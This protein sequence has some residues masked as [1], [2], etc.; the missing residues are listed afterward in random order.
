M[1][2]TCCLGERDG[3]APWVLQEVRSHLDTLKDRLDG[4]VAIIQ[5]PRGGS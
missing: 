3:E 2:E 4:S 5:P 1:H